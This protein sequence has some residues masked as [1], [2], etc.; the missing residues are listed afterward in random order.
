MD[1]VCP[2]ARFR[3]FIACMSCCFSSRYGRVHSRLFQT[4][5]VFQPTSGRLTQPRG[6]TAPHGPGQLRQI[7]ISHPQLRTL[8]VA[9]EG[10]NSLHR[11]VEE[12]VELLSE[13]HS[14]LASKSLT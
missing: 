10:L 2:G 13:E 14:P 11:N 3:A 8:T 12:E 5:A 1:E 6:D 4:W 7:H 9:A